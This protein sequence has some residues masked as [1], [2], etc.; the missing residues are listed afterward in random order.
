M[1]AKV[2]AQVRNC[3]SVSE[4]EDVVVVVDAELTRHLLAGGVMGSRDRGILSCCG[5]K[6]KHA[7]EAW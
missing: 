7:R 1:E 3:L 5:Q 4:D 6:K 2:W